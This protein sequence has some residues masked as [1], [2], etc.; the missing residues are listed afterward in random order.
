MS[1]AASNSAPLRPPE[2]QIALFV[3]CVYAPGDIVESRLIVNRDAPV[4]SSWQVASELAQ[5]AA[6]LQRANDDGRNI[7][8]G[9][10]PRTVRGN[11]TSAKVC[12]GNTCGKCEKCVPLARC[13][14]ADFDKTTIEAVRFKLGETS[15]P[16]PTMLVCSGNG[17][18]SHWRLTEPITA[19]AVWSEWQ[20]GLSALLGSDS[21]IHD[22]PRILRL[23][24]FANVKE[25][26]NPKPCYIV[27]A[28]PARI[29]DL[30]DFHE[31]IPAQEPQ[32]PPAGNG[33]TATATG[34][35]RSL[36]RAVAEML[37][38][39]VKDEKDGSSRLFACAC[40]CVEAGLSDNDG[41]EAIRLYERIAPFPKT[42]RDDDIRNRLRDARRKTG[43]KLAANEPEGL[44]PV[45]AA[46]L[47]QTYPKLRKPVVYGLLRTGETLNVVGCS[48]SMKSWL[49]TDLAL[50]KTAGGQW[51]N[52]FETPAG[53]VLVIDNELHNETLAHRI[54][55]VAAARGISQ[56]MFTGKLDVLSLRGRLRNIF[57]LGSLFAQ[58]KGKYDL[59]LCD[60]LYRLL[61]ADGEVD[62]NSNSS[63]TNVY[64]VLDSYAD[65]AQAAIVVVHHS[66]KGSQSEKRI[67]DVGAGGGAQSRACDSHLVIREHADP[68]AVAVDAVVRSWPPPDSFAMRWVYPVWMP[69]D[70]LDPSKLKTTIPARRG[71]GQG[72]TADAAQSKFVEL[73]PFKPI[74][75][76]PL[77]KLA[78]DAGFTQRAAKT[79]LETAVDDGSV[80]RKVGP[81]RRHQYVRA[82]REQGE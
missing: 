14:V 76:E 59:I 80:L 47:I 69:A 32:K 7:Y 27:E 10:N 77:L 20:K 65:T 28:D 31:A 70:D 25:R 18:H 41:S 37:R 54:P 3:A 75:R 67:T 22:P 36:R 53:R 73:V 40:R 58:S 66:T 60:A 78:T 79:A 44:E 33:K 62:E 4:N 43:P 48:K 42:Y 6:A 61:P 34:D 72:L 24:G 51:L 26:E 46:K 12:P 82:A 15:L 16:P 68:D 35:D 71:T 45:D 8:V 5:N 1:A 2:E 57:Q 81:H 29:Y 64:N 50:C 55:Q 21:A 74:G 39:T 30:C 63:L 49:V 52:R 38:I 13:L 23:P 56:Q 9:I 11:G 19:L 17:V